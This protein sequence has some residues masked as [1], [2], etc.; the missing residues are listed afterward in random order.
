M[1]HYRRRRRRGKRIVRVEIDARKVE[2][3][4]RRRYLDPEDRENLGEI[5]FAVSALVSDVLGGFL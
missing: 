4:V 3:L 2:E 5:E 1:R